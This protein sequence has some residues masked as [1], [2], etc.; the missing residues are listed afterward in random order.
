MTLKMAGGFRE[1]AHGKKTGPSLT[2][3]ISDYPQEN[4]RQII[5]YLKS[6]IIF[7][8]CMGVFKD[9]LDDTRNFWIAPHLLTDGSWLWYNDLSYYVET[10]HA[11]VPPKFV[12]AMKLNQWK[13][14]PEN[15][16]D[17]NELESR[18]DS[19]SIEFY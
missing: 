1:L 16:I 8:A 17:L 14:P 3:C 10:Y 11:R 9:V 5:Q 6:G 18:Y 15:S 7:M 4:E 2:E 13:V 12:R 19:Q